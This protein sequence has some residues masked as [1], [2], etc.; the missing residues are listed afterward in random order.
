MKEIFKLALE[1]EGAKVELEMAVDEDE[2]L[3]RTLLLP[4]DDGGIEAW[5]DGAIRLDLAM[6]E[7][8]IEGL[9]KMRHR[10]KRENT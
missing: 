5:E 1:G 10:L 2:V 6:V 3:I 9:E 4:D 7:E 8:L